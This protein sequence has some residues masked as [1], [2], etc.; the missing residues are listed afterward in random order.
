MERR[1][2]ISSLACLG[3]MSMVKPTGLFS[4]PVASSGNYTIEQFED[5]GLAHFSYV[6]MAGRKA[7]VIDPK[8][9]PQVYYDYT[10]KHGAEIVGIIETHPH[11]DFASAHLEMHK[12]LNVPI[13]SSSLTEPGYPSTAFDDGEFIKLTDKVGLRSLY[14]PGH[15]P[16]HISVVLFENVKDIALFSGDSLLIGDVGRPD[17]RDFSNNI[18]SQRQQ[19]AEMMYDTIHEKFARLGDDVL[20]YPAHGAGSLCGKSIRK[21][22][23]STIGYE[24]QHN[25]AFEKR[26]KSE[27]VSL[28]LSDQPFIPKYFPY[29]VGL[30]IKGAPDLAASLAGVQRLPKNYQPRAGSLVID[31]RPAETFKASYIPNAV[32]IQDGGSFATWLGSMVAPDAGFY[33]AGADEESLET[34]MYKA[35]SIGYESKIKGAFVY[36][37]ANGRQFAVFDQHSFRPEENKYTHIDTRTAKEVQQEPI[38]KNSINI[39]LQELDRRISEI[40]TD[41]P[42][43]VSCAS[44][45]RSAIASSMVK[46]FLPNAQVYDLGA[47]VVEYKK[48]TAKN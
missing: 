3:A 18:E 1:T 28:V 39:P 14:S 21:A 4:K 29:S 40:P 8:R 37:T 42:I 32:N 22:A 12:R 36:D 31:S 10:K 43:L 5:K 20:L 30:N 7:I 33:L 35:A 11:A 16:D 2:F 27:F 13:Y 24:K 41:K 47:D 38:F 26:T 44:G 23:S 48:A 9:D 25:Y 17:L 19:L 46:K 6:I 15:A 45:Y 34:A